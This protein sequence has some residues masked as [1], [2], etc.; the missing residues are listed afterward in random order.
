VFHFIFSGNFTCA[1]LE[2]AGLIAA[3]NDGRVGG[4]DINPGSDDEDEDNLGNINDAKNP[5]PPPLLPASRK[6]QLPTR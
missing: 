1:Q 5:P 4:Q 2:A 3:N 6:R